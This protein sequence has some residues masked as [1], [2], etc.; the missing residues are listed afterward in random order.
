VNG[1]VVFLDNGRGRD[2]ESKGENGKEKRRPSSL[3]SIM[4]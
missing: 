2:K 1:G 4:V 3:V